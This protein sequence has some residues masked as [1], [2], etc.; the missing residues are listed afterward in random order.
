M[1]TNEFKNSRLIVVC[2]LGAFGLTYPLLSLFN[3]A[4]FVFGIPWL[5]FYLFAVWGILIGLVVFML[6][7]SRPHHPADSEKRG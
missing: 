7:R 2:F 1:K 5:I 4:T 6:W 3:R